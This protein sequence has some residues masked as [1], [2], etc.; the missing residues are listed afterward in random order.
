[1]NKVLKKFI[2]CAVVLI[3]VFSLSQIT[4]AAN[5]NDTTTTIGLDK[6]DNYEDFEFDMPKDGKVKINAQIWDK[7]TVPGILTVA[8]QKKYGEGSPKVKEFTGITVAAPLTDLE[9]ELSEGKYYISYK[10]SNAAGDL[11]D[12]SIALKCTAEVLPTT[13]VNIPE[14]KVSSINSFDELTNKGYNELK[15]GDGVQESDKNIVVPFTVKNG[16]GVYITMLSKMNNFDEITGTIYKDKECTNAVGKS[17]MLDTVDEN[18]NYIRTLSGSGTYYIKFTLEND[19]RE[20]VG[21]TKLLVKLYDLNGADRVISIGKPTLSYQDKAGKKINYKISVKAKSYLTIDVDLADN[22]KSG[23]AS[24]CLLNKNKKVITKVSKMY[25]DDMSNSGE[26]GPVKKYYTVPAGTYYIQ[27]ST[28]NNIYQLS[29]SSN[30]ISRDAGSSK[31]KAKLLK[32]QKTYA[33]GYITV[34]DSTAKADWFKFTVDSTQQF[35]Q[36]YMQYALDGKFDYEVLNSKGKVLY[37]LS[38]GIGSN[39]GRYETACSWHFDKGTYYIK[40][41]KTGASSSIF[42]RLHLFNY[43]YLN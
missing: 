40:V 30:K 6:R 22:S 9:V 12:T 15:F 13:V 21:E 31:A 43:Q 34:A 17:F 4:A 2:A 8:I 41:Y 42:Y 20:A 26:Y 3:A 39:E 27:V 25:N 11:K 37:K 19:E 18:A 29:I 36:V 24:F 28:S 32:V 33:S 7:G 1:M 38:K 14:L 10:L 5:P 23:A 16:S 35:V